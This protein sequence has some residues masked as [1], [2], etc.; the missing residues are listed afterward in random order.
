MVAVALTEIMY[1]SDFRCHKKPTSNKSKSWKWK[2]KTNKIVAESAL[3]LRR[4]CLYKGVDL[5]ITLPIHK[6]GR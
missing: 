3:R 1:F 6:K 2:F 4:M 5:E